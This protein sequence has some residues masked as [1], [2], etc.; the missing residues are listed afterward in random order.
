M[1]SRGVVRSSF[2]FAL[3]CFVF[4]FKVFLLFHRKRSSICMIALHSVTNLVLC[5]CVSVFFCLCLWFVIFILVGPLPGFSTVLWLT[6]VLELSGRVGHPEVAHFSSGCCCSVL[7]G[8]FRCCEE[9]NAKEAKGKFPISGK[10][11]LRL[12]IFFVY[13]R[14]KQIE[15]KVFGTLEKGSVFDIRFKDMTFTIMCLCFV[16][17]V[18]LLASFTIWRKSHLYNDS[19]SF[20]FLGFV[21]LWR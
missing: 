21:W 13:G 18:K 5:L 8:C 4:F 7:L 20:Y 16:F 3:F 19:F 17:W 1:S 11:G 9:L 14:N 12:S 6:F 2:R 10:E 15:T